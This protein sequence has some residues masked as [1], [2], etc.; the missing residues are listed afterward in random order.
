MIDIEFDPDL[1]VDLK[2]THKLFAILRDKFGCNKPAFALYQIK[3][4]IKSGKKSE[5]TAKNIRI[6]GR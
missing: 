2:T 1:I 4:K 5:I 3:R 6:W